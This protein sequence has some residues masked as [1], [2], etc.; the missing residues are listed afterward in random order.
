VTV[1][2]TTLDASWR[3]W[4]ARR[5]SFA[6]VHLDSAAAGRASTEVL[7]A[8]A[9]H[10]RRE[11]EVGA[12]VAEA[13]ASTTLDTG[14]AQ[15]GALMGVPAAGVAFVESATAALQALLASWPLPEHPTIAVAPSEWGPNLRAFRMH[16]VETRQLDVDDNGHIDIDALRN[17]LASRPPSV[18]HVDGVAAHRGLVQPVDEIVAA[19]RAA[20][21]PVWLDAAQALGHVDAASEADAVIATSRKWLCGPRGVGVLGIAE[22]WW[23]RLRVEPLV[24][25]PDRSVVGRLESDEANVAGRIGLCVAV[26]DYVSC[27]PAAVQHRL[28]EVGSRA[29][30]AL[31]DVPGWRL[32]HTTGSPGAIVALLPTNGQDVIAERRRLLADH[33]ILV[34]ASQPARAPL[35]TTSATLRISPHVDITDPQLGALA[36]ALAVARR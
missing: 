14:R 25:Q 35:E 11:S 30:D 16:G 21:V 22:R 10:G 7:R 17:L 13:E 6:G 1:T 2:N 33:Q 29:R 9:E 3:T 24:L 12:Y 36:R 4:S 28:A 26:Q 18:V 8:V 27:G 34:T 19:C 20:G 23:S 5:P 32:V 15:L 31:S